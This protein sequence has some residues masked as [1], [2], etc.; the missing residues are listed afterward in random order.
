MGVVDLKK[1]SFSIFIPKSR[2]VKDGWSSM[3]ETLR[4]L[5]VVFGRKESQQVEAT[6]LKPKLVKS[7]VEVVQMPRNKGRAVV[8]V[9][10]RKEEM[11]RNLNKLGHCL[12]GFWNP[13]SERGEDLKSWGSQMAK[14]WGLKGKLGMA[15]LERGKVLLEFELVA[16]AKK[17]LSHGRISVGGLLLRLEGWSPETG[18]LVEGEKRCEAWVRFVG[19]T[20]FIMGSSHFEKS[21]GGMRGFLGSRHP[22][23]EVGRIAVGSD[24]G[25]IK[26]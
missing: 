23:G 6:L 10:V 14:I 22:N 3:V 9:E 18:C 26:W 15:K 2:G 21:R 13:S 25:E 24:F 5:G 12:V 19:L 7:F 8:R 20:R 4:S 16:K 17:A 1:K 11:S